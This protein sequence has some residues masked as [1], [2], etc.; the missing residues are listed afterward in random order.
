MAVYVDDA[1]I[2]ARVGRIRARWSHLY[3]DSQDEL[4]AFAASI[5]LKRAWFQPGKP[6]GGKPSRLW[7]YD[8][9]DAMRARA[10][11]SRRAA[12]RDPRVPGDHRPPGRCNPAVT[13]SI[14]RAADGVASHRGG[15]RRVARGRGRR[16][17]RPR[18][19]V[20]PGRDATALRL[21]PRADPGAGPP[22]RGVLFSALPA[23]TS[24]VPAGGRPGRSRRAWP[25]AT[26]RLRRPA[27]SGQGMAV[28]RSPGLSRR[29]R[30]RGPHRAAGRLR[31]VGAVDVGRGAARRAGA[32]PAGRPGRRMAS[33]R[34][35][36]GV[37]LAAARLGAGHL[38][39]WPADQP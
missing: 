34:A 18:G 22:R 21:V 32:V 12:G 11:A 16:V 28:P 3:A 27:V 20:A 7:H 5:G 37:Q 29:G 23:G 9:T 36:H 31:R 25:P 24:P 8:V 4:H 38:L 15:T 30:P 1:R 26:T 2:P 17:A 13:S 19:R 14:G 35:A 10:I 39:R 33:R 6:I